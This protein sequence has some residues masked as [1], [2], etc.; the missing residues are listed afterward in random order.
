MNSER[1]RRMPRGRG[2]WTR[3]L[4]SI[5]TGG[6]AAIA[7]AAA[8]ILVV[9][10]HPDDDVASCSG[11]VA[12]A[13]ARG[14]SVRVVFL[15]NGDYL[16]V[17][18]GLQRENEAVD[19]M[20]GYL[21]QT[22]DNLLFLGY[23]DAG[24]RELYDSA[25]SSSD[26]FTGV[27]GRTT[28][29]AAR[30]LGR[31]DYHTYAHG[32]PAPYN[33]PAIVA[34]LAEIIGGYL[35]DHI[36]VTSVWDSH[37]DHSTAYLLLRDAL[38]VVSA[39]H[40]A[41][42]PTIHSTL[43]HPPGGATWP[44]AP[45]PTTFFTVPPGLD[46][47]NLVWSERESLDVP[48]AMQSTL[49]ADNP[50]Y[51]AIDTHASQ[52]GM[53]GFLGQF[54]H[55]D[56]FF[57]V[58]AAQ[59]TAV[60]PRPDAGAD[61][62][63][64]EGA[65]V[66]LD[67]SASFVDAG[68][69]PAYSWRQVS[70]PAVALDDPTSATPTFVAPTGL[71]ADA[72]LGFE[73]TVADGLF[74]SIPDGTIVRV[75]AT[76]PPATRTNIAGTATVTASSEATAEGQGAAKAVD[77]VVDGY[78]GDSSREWSTVEEK[79]GAWIQLT[80]ASARTIDR[81]VLYDRP[82]SDDQILAGTLLFSDGTTLAVGPLDNAGAATAYDFPARTVTWVR[83]TVTQVS[84]RTGNVG[85]AEFEV[86]EPLGTP[87]NHAP[88]AAAGAPQAVA[89]GATVALD[90]TAS[91]DPDGGALAYAWT[92]TSGP[93]VALS[94][95]T[96]ATPSFTAP[97]GLS[98]DATLVFSL[99]VNDGQLSSPASTTTV[100]VRSS[101][102]PPTRTNV[103]AQATVTASSESTWSQQTAA[104]A[105]DGVVGGYPGDYTREWATNGQ[106][107]GAWIQL[108][109]AAAQTLDR[110]V[111]YD[112]PNAND[113][114]LAGT[115]LFSDGTTIAVGP[116]DNAGAA[117]A[118]D[119]AARAVT[120]VRLTVTQVSSRTGNVGLAEMEAW[121]EPGAAT[122][123]APIA[124]AGASQTVAEGAA[125]ALDGSA[126]YDPDGS[127]VAYAWSQ[128]SG[129]SVTLSGATTARPTFTAP[130]G[131]S[132]DATL[133]FALVVNDGQLSSPA[134]TTTVTVHYAAPPA[135]RAN[136]AS[137]ATVT[138]SS[139]STWSQQTAAK[140]V[141][142]VVAGYPGDYT[143]EW[144][145]NGQGVGAW[146]QL[147]WT[148]ARTIDRIVLYDRPNANDQI[149]A[150]TLLFSDGT[151]LVVGPLDNAGAAT[152]YDFPARSATSVRL[153]VTQVSANTGNVGLAEMEV[154]ENTGT[155]V[156]RAPVANAGAAQT[157]AE[158]ANVILDGTAS[159]DPDGDAVSYAWT[160]TSGPTVTLSSA[161]SATPAFTAP[162]G[163]AAD[164]TL[165]FSLVVNDGKVNGAAASTTVTVRASAPP[166]ARTN[167]APQATATAS[168]ESTWS[169]QTAA[170][171]IDG[172]AT[173]YP[174]D[175]RR[176]WATNGQGVGAWIRL[177]WSAAQTINR[178]VLY[179]RPNS[180]DQML[181]GT[182]RFSDGTTVA[183]GPL[184]NN[185]TATT[186]D[187]AARSA[188]WVELTVTAVSS[189]TENVGL[190]EFEAYTPGN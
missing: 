149:L 35:P 108:T 42:N 7:P 77:G 85:L 25:T 117:T 156:N 160:Q 36:F 44:A 155:A 62:S 60:P 103:A 164:A 177:T 157:V 184:A 43:V 135:T 6:L 48:P 136:I 71:S 178:V 165:V 70:G 186:F 169:Q 143:R 89:E 144:A 101:A 65:L 114:I 37:G 190:A 83:L 1:G 152:T 49:F 127:A 8:S 185:G 128:T 87:A 150:G 12:R 182:L 54:L 174:T 141:D 81:I 91:Y 32:S 147:T 172:S 18:S 22:E 140:A 33:R 56:E 129:P 23:P 74:T 139:E 58:E 100:T 158:G 41:Y 92:Q 80:W 30:G 161:T 78:P 138:A 11:I 96:S 15:T 104:K 52:D 183:V 72:T 107:V 2:R 132:A 13:A 66:R 20:V 131:L 73:L 159:Y 115:L 68:R 122:N 162:S 151:T 21:G 145:T 94:D 88:V 116:L 171:A 90:G 153:T 57:W 38:N 176:E 51:L 50:K 86:W 112:R 118:Y 111:L 123:H 39:A 95:P 166:A 79:A 187:F 142:G 181:A 170:K 168:S 61:Q 148:T 134:S 102:P 84:A 125:V 29:Y 53:R 99:V 173:G 10:P 124:S 45:D 82:N 19:A 16:G 167:V 3:I 154:W 63:A 146:I 163:L 179:D 126:S 40:P 137:Q 17:D 189:T 121:A 4:A 59:G 180:S 75:A 188:T 67:G 119:F 46:Q 105:V 9:A 130:S 76:A 175:Y 69:T 110:I 24:L 28:T 120:W 64:A 5:L 31:T 98:A 133:V 34:D 113:Q 97:T 47:T 14:E 93:S 55:K 26:L 27:N 106:G 109:W